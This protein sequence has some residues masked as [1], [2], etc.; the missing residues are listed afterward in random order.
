MCEEEGIWLL[1]VA[2]NLTVFGEQHLHSQY[3]MLWDMACNVTNCT[4]LYCG[5]LFVWLELN[6]DS[7]VRIHTHDLHYDS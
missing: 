1:T 4:L 6:L 2:D 3:S 5:S 7:Q